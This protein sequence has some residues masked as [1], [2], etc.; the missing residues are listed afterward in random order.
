MSSEKSEKVSA[1]EA[2]K[3]SEK[4]AQTAEKAI[5]DTEKT[6]ETVRKATRKA[7]KKNANTVKKAAKKAVDTGEKI[8]SKAKEKTMQNQD[9]FQNITQQVANSN[10][11]YMEAWVQSGTKF[12]KNMEECSKAV[13]GMTQDAGQKSKEAMKSLMAC[14]TLNEFTE[15]QTKLA[16]QG[17]DDMVE[18][19]SKLTEMSIRC[20]TEC[21]E[22]L[23]DQMTKTMKKANKAA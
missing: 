15:T 21:A 3:A 18:N 16:Q 6:A 10:K 8:Q 22:P 17:F 9:Y 11:E 20:A 12:F 1:G 13:M 5:K 4:P 7:A 23:N 2:A 14:K 19:T